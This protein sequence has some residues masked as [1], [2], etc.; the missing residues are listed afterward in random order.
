MINI[1]LLLI[2]ILTFISLNLVIFIRF[3]QNSKNKKILLFITKLEKYSACLIIIILSYLFIDMAIFRFLGHGYPSNQDHEKIQRMPTPYDFFSGKPNYRDHNSDGFRGKDFERAK[4]NQ[5]SIAFF[6]GSTG[7]KGNP[8]IIDLI[9]QKLNLHNVDTIVYNFSSA[10]SNHNQHLHRLL[11]FSNYNFDIILF[12]GGYNE[13]FQTLYADPRAGYPF[14][15]WT[16]GELHPAKFTLLKYSP[17]F[18]E[19]DKRTGRI[20]GISKIRKKVRL[21]SDEWIDGL[22]ENY[23]NTLLGSK[24]LTQEFINPNLCNKSIFISIYQPISLAKMRDG[25]L[26]KLD[27]G[28]KEK[29]VDKTKSRIKNYNFIYDLSNLYEEDMFE[30]SVHVTDEAKEIMASK[31][32]EIVRNN[33]EKKCITN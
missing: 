20:S 22:L 9:G 2:V 27:K 31:I 8:P 18:A 28:F 12:Y 5:L 32:T 7:Y 1:L 26:N 24:K 16:V 25:L 30:D 10:A 13:T 4:K 19:I 29:I 3:K 33:L 17:L 6:G 21:G 14:N 15:F 11:K 23:I